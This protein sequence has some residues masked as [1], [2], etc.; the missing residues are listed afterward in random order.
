MGDACRPGPWE[1]NKALNTI[2]QVSQ[3]LFI[4]FAAIAATAFQ[5]FTHPNGEAS[6]MSFQEVTCGTS[7]HTPII[8]CAVLLCLTFVVPFL[9]LTFWANW[10]APLMSL[11]SEDATVSV[12]LV[13]FRFLFYRFRPCTWWWGS[14]VA[15]RQLL[16][17]FASMVSPD[18]AYA[19]ILYVMIVLVVYVAFCCRAWPWKNDELNIA[20]STSLVLLLLFIFAA[21]AFIRE[22]QTRSHS[23]TA[24]L[25]V[26][27][28]SIM[29][30][31]SI[32]VISAGVSLLLTG[33]GGSYGRLYKASPEKR[34]GLAADVLIFG[35]QI[36]AMKT[37]Q[38]ST[39]LECIGSIERKQLDDVI[40]IFSAIHVGAIRRSVSRKQG[41]G[42]LAQ[43]SSTQS[44][45]KDKE[46]MDGFF[47]ELTISCEGTADR[48]ARSNSKNDDAQSGAEGADA[49]VN[50]ENKNSWQPDEEAKRWET[51][52]TAHA[53]RLFE[54]TNI[55]LTPRGDGA[56]TG[57]NSPRLGITTPKVALVFSP[58]VTP[59]SV[60]FVQ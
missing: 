46:Q 19:Q 20:E 23:W 5:C 1:I 56:A 9:G 60:A 34:L 14:V 12:H 54:G 32:V 39:L 15:I 57:S 10:Q 28:Y 21:G 3:T 33:R 42:R 40:D 52:A 37:T 6:L 53:E 50:E 44:Q 48:L 16:L 30:I 18:D 25:L 11:S 26:L 29:L 4:A 45:A 43:I 13:R 31:L 7:D 59:R 47:K 8:V 22:A 35:E 38:I 41:L 24:L 49:A 58:P 27:F 51:N 2:G 36:A 17:A 55:M